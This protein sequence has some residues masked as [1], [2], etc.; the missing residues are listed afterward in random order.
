MRDND[1]VVPAAQVVNAQFVPEEWD[2]LRQS[3]ISS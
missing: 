3:Y 2:R 1:P